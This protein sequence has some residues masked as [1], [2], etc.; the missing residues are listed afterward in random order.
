MLLSYFDETLRYGDLS[1]IWS[2]ISFNRVETNRKR[3]I[4]SNYGNRI[5]MATQ[6]IY[7]L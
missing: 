6:Y 3:R 1:V 4:S 7:D 5:A 2:T